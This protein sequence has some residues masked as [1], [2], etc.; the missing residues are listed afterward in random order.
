MSVQGEVVMSTE[1]E[2]IVLSILKGRIPEMWMRKSYPSLKPLGSYVNDFLARLNFL[3]VVSLQHCST[4]LK[5]CNLNTRIYHREY[6]LSDSAS[7]TLTMSCFEHF[8]FVI[9]IF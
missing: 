3:Q 1:L 4:V 9:I 5:H 8:L 2:D 6:D 7:V